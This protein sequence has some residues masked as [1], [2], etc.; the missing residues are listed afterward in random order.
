MPAET[1]K[2]PEA[3]LD[4]LV[5]LRRHGPSTVADLVR[6]LGSARPMT[7]GSMATLLGRLEQKKLVARRKGEVGKAFV[8][9]A[10]SRAEGAVRG[11][12]RRLLGRVL[13]GDRVVLVASLLED[14]SLDEDEIARLEALVGELA[15]GRSTRRRRRN[16]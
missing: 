10:T 6:R 7:H 12:V 3:E 11:T 16:P 1:P 13:G 15:A 4:V 14:A 8:F 9:S 5:A 2:I